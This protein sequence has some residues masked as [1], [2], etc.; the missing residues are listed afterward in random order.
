MTYLALS[1]GHASVTAAVWSSAG[2][3]SLARAGCEPEPRSWWAGVETAVGALDADLVAVTAVGCAGAGD[4]F[5]LLARDGE[6]LSVV[7]SGSSWGSLPRVGWVAGARDFVASLLTGRLASDPTVASETG[8]FTPDGHLSA[9]A[10]ASRGIDAAWLPPQKGS[11]EV[12]GDLLL[13]AARRLGLRSRLPVVMGASSGACAVEGAGALPV[14]P[15]VS[16]GP[17]VVVSVPVSPP[18]AVPGAGV[19]LLAGG[20]SYQV[21]RAVVDGDP[22]AVGRVVSE[23]APEAK[24]LY[25]AGSADRSW[26]VAL[27]S[28][29]GL[30]VAHR[31]SAEHETLGLAMLTATGVGEHLDRDLAN[32]VAYV[33][34]PDPGRYAALR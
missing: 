32:P 29:T 20:R 6:P 3:L 26:P 7:T 24:F 1:V 31:K 9:D 5:V 16:Y 12:L 34:E 33:D 28:V 18:A 23:L 22:A 10:V 11:T 15:L 30:P 27:A 17:S 21:Y 25:A 13:P 4:L 8:F 19:T 2:L 14:A